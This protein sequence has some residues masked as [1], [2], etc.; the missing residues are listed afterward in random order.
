[1]TKRILL[2]TLLFIIIF[3]SSCN[4]A[5]N[6]KSSTKENAP[7]C[8]HSFID[9]VI[10]EKTCKKDGL[11][12]H[13]CVYCSYTYDEVVKKVLTFDEVEII[14]KKNEYSVILFLAYL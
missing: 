14:P 1:M 9:E 13:R 8:E 2:I 4:N 7:S 5:H 12:R 10:K 11:I 6:S 3:L